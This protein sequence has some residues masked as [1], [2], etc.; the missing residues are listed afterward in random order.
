MSINQMFLSV[1]V[2]IAEHLRDAAT[3]VLLWSPENVF[4][5]FSSTQS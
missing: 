5:S 3:K 2:N 1:T 4:G